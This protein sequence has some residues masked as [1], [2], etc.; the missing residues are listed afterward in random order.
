MYTTRKTYYPFISPFDPCKPMRM[1]TYE[2]P[3]QLYMGFQPYN[4]PQFNPKEALIH[5]TL[6][7][8]LVAPYT[9]PYKDLEEGCDS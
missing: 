5:G 4:L 3:P 8:T 2:T 7:P 6:W 9:N 1:K